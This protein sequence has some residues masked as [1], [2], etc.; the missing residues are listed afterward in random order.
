MKH[1]IFA[2]YDVK[3]YAYLPPFFMP[4]KGMAA[5][6]F[7][8]CVESESHQ[9]GKHP[10]DYTLFFIGSFDDETA[11]IVSI[12][13]ETVLTGLQARA[14]AARDADDDEVAAAVAALSNEEVR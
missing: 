10:E 14:R 5:R 8:D 3:A 7:S 1:R 13:P 11:E 4:E 12:T 2:V 6:V 9:F